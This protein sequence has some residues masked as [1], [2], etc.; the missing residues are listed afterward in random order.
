MESLFKLQDVKNIC[1][2]LGINYENFR[3]HNMLGSLIREVVD[4]AKNNY[5]LPD[6]IIHCRRLRPTAF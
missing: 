3:D 2:D 4:F 5:R 6:L 1:M